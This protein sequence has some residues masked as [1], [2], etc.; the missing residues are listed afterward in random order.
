MF[1][2]SKISG[3]HLVA[4]ITNITNSELLHNID[5]VKILLDNIC[6]QYNYTILCKNEHQFEPFGFT[7]LYLLAESHLSIH[8]FPEQNYFAFDI[9]TCRENQP[10]SI[11]EDIYQTLLSNFGATGSYQIIQRGW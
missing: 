4:D 7:I 10:D 5:C 3:K 8:T 1:S 6:E 2:Q 9:Y 11:Y